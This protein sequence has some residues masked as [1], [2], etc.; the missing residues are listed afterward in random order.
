MGVEFRFF[1]ADECVLSA[2]LPL[3]DFSGPF[4]LVSSSHI[5]PGRQPF[6]PLGSQIGLCFNDGF[7]ACFLLLNCGLGL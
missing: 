3:N 2:Q 6:P 4:T 1:F 5:S 7:T